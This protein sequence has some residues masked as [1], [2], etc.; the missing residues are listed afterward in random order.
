M[1]IVLGVEYDGTDFSGWQSQDGCRTVQDEV[2]KAIT[3]VANEPLQVVCAGR[4]DS[5]VHAFGQVVHFDTEVVRSDRSWVLG[6]NSN[7]PADI[8]INWAMRTN[9]EFHAR[10]GAL[11]RRYRYIILNRPTRS[12]VHRHRVCWHHQPLD[13]SRMAEAAQH[14]VGE[15]DFTSFRALACQ[16]HQPVRHIHR[17]D[18]S[19]QGEYII[20]DI[21]ANAFLHHMVRNIAGTL[22]KIGEGQREPGWV[23][24]LIALKDRSQAAPTAPAHGL[25]LVA[26]KYPDTFALPD[27]VI[28]HA[29]P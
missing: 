1:R 26:V 4:T 16:A 3:F 8:N 20:I 28:P 7:L 6:C 12:G 23:S 13:E 17:L 19:R 29:I 15:H 14:F 21:E 27:H 11:S 24:D 9:V 18:V 22:L 10:F 5:G 2:E 25:Y